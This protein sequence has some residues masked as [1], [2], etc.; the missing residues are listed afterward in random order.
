MKTKFKDFLLYSMACIG[1]VSLF[2]SAYQS[3][4]DQSKIGKY[5]ISTAGMG[6]DGSGFYV[7]V[8]ILDT[9]TGEVTKEVQP[10]KY[11]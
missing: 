3:Q 2:L 11:Y 4:P 1:A 10:G 6:S 5:Q 9:E 7:Y 8:Y